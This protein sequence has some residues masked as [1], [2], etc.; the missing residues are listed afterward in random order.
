VIQKTLQKQGFFMAD[1][2]GTEKGSIKICSLFYILCSELHC[3]EQSF[4]FND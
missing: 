3:N 4:Y 1:Q 2:N